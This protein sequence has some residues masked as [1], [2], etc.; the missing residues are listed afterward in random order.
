MSANLPPTPPQ[1][2]YASPVFEGRTDLR[3]IALR[4]RAIMVCI[5]VEIVMIVL[6]F[7]LPAELRL[8]PALG[9]FAAGITGTVFAFMLGIAVYGAAVGIILGI[10]T[11]IPYLGL[12]FLLII[13]GKATGILR[14]HRIRVGL[15][16]ADLSQIPA[17]GQIRV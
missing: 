15:M 9:M 6:M 1:L 17:P 3:E 11:L 14:Q 16:G 2:D 7:T 13:N 8:F 4:Q 5:L 12:I 10:L